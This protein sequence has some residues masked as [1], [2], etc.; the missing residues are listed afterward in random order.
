MTDTAKSSATGTVYGS[1][2]GMM[3]GTSLTIACGDSPCRLAS[4]INMNNTMMAV[5]AVSAMR[6]AQDLAD[7]VAL[8]DS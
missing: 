4:A 3:N 6:N 5:R 1:V 7:H 8:Q 2:L